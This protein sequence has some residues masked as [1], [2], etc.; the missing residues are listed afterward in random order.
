MI[1]VQDI[2]FVRYQVCDLDRM[3]AFLD[4]FGLHRVERT[5]GAL[6][7][8]AAG[9]MHHVHISELGPENKALGFGLLAHSEADLQKLAAHLGV[10]VEENP[11]PGGGQRVRFTD[12]AGFLVDVIHGQAEQAPREVRG[13]LAMNSAVDRRRLG[14]A[15]RLAPKPSSVMRLGHVAVLVADF[16]KMLQFYQDVLGFRP[17]DTYWAG[18]EQNVIAAFMHCGLG[19][20]WT[21]HHTIALITAQEGSSRFDHSA[22]EVLDL[23]DLV[24][25]G[26]YLKQR[27]HRHSWGVGRHIQGSQ[28]FDYWRD[29]FGNKIEHWTDGDLVNNTSAVGSAAISE[30]ELMQWAPPLNPEFFQ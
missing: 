24:Q 21:D 10:R 29:P 6:Y 12:P 16:P 27:G 3:E 18:A 4:D 19:E 28:L 13:A 5:S 30:N 9:R 26:E 14:K 17:S 1:T 25:G 2:A 20:Q 11:E 8:R 22:F 23:D 7:M 15:I